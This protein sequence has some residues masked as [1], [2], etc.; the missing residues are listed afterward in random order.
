MG[1][2]GSVIPFFIKKR[3]EGKIPITDKSM[4]RFN[5]SL[6]GGVDMVMHAIEHS[7]GG[8]IFIPKIPSYKITD[9]AKAIAPNCEIEIIGIRPGEKVHEE[10]I[11][12]SPAIS[13]EFEWITSTGAAPGL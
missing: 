4:T 2:N 7:W 13:T 11:T 9:I 12:E 10:M 1:S 8:E 3:S 5:I 6:Q